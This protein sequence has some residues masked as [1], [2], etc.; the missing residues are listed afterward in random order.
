MIHS[1]KRRGRGRPRL[2]ENIDQV[3]EKASRLAQITETLRATGRTD[4]GAAV[5]ASAA[6]AATSGRRSGRANQHLKIKKPF[7]AFE[8]DFA[9]YEKKMDY[10]NRPI[11]VCG[12]G[13][14][15]L[16]AS[17]PLYDKGVLSFLVAIAEP[18]NRPQFIHHY[19][20]TPKSLLA[21]TSIGLDHE[22]IIKTLETLSKNKTLPETVITYIV[23]CTKRY[24]KAKLLLRDG[25]YYVESL[26]S[27]ILRTLLN[28]SEVIRKA[29][30]NRIGDNGTTAGGDHS[31]AGKSGRVATGGGGVVGD[32]VEGPRDS[33][34]RV[35]AAME[36]NPGRLTDFARTLY[37]VDSDSDDVDEGEEDDLLF[38][39][40]EEDS[41]DED[42][43]EKTVPTISITFGAEGKV[44]SSQFGTDSASKKRK[45]KKK[46]RKKKRRKKRRKKLMKEAI[47]FEIQRNKYRDVRKDAL[48][49][50][51][52]L[53]EEYD[54]SNDK[55][56]QTLQIQ[57]KSDFP[58][59]PYQTHAL[60][61][62]FSNKRA[63]S[64]IIVLPC[65]AGKTYVGITAAATI[66]K[67][68]LVIT[69]NNSVVQQWRDQFFKF[70]NIKPEHVVVFSSQG[71][72]QEKEEEIRKL[73]AMRAGRGACVCIATYHM[74]AF[75]GSGTRRSEASKRAMN[76]ISQTDWGVLIMD[77]V[78]I[79]PAK[80]FQQIV[81]TTQSHC[82]L[83]L[84]ATLVREDNKINDLMYLVGPKL[85]E[86]N[87]MD[88]TNEGYLARVQCVEVWCSM[89][90]FFYREYLKNEDLTSS[91]EDYPIKRKKRE[92]LYTMNPNKFKAVE[93]LVHYHEQRGDKILVFCDKITAL[94]MYATKM[95]RLVVCGSTKI[96]ER[97]TVFSMFKNT[98]TTNTLFVSKIADVGIDLPEANVLIQIASH[99]GSQ[100][101]EAQ[102]LGRILR[103][104]S[105][106]PQHGGPNAFFYTLVSA[107]TKETYYSNGR[108]QYLCNQG[109][110]FKVV[111]D[112]VSS[113][114][115]DVGFESKFFNKDQGEKEWMEA[116]LRKAKTDADEAEEA[117]VI[118]RL[119][120]TGAARTARTTRNTGGS[121]R[122]AML[123]G[124]M[125]S[126]MEYTG[127]GPS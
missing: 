111:R 18:V 86:A 27:T 48:R 66:K 8:Y 84:T 51:Y 101:Q 54:F 107:D 63:R 89:T 22:G 68:T 40:S 117:G 38:D 6:A 108:R 1:E 83:G 60:D 75:G 96:S 109:Y 41:E 81:S 53:T 126:Y 103:P 19:R 125:G 64:G 121:D 79:A 47:V 45:K 55:K 32:S 106:Q 123:S 4:Y 100:R 88:L 102:R 69:I 122:A 52:P 77:E 59:R 33:F 80:T 44:A 50:G 31:G 73:E 15:F 104:K 78:H 113:A 124:G 42:E 99:Y 91:D 36:E 21:A 29:R 5:A 16:E 67:C 112:L 11:W 74:I 23:E 43:D 94:L 30:V 116:L 114:E 61:Q 37:G 127:R 26:D 120:A 85:Y 12:N 92:L 119:T 13:D 28:E 76:V 57:R 7:G 34:L 56:S 97:L 115:K 10:P 46:K 14:I 9:T 25:K 98:S 71:T 49:L 17:T 24:G 82:K 3:E 93:F 20:L 87:W 58:L 95:D 2:A 65:G 105:N 35:Q 62:M 118:A 39:D 70:A 110:T 90:P 72:S